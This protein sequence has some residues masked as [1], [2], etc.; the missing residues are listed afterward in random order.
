MHRPSGVL[1]EVYS[2][3]SQIHA[4]NHNGLWFWPTH[5]VVAPLYL[6]LWS[7]LSQVCSHPGCWPSP[8]F[9]NVPGLDPLPLLWSSQLQ[10][11]GSILLLWRPLPQD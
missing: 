1:A 4:W 8:P 9:P 11:D 5:S 6:M 2:F 10:G 7:L 3:I